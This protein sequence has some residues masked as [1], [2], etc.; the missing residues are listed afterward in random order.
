MLL[1]FSLC[2]VHLSAAGR[3][4]MP[5][6]PDLTKFSIHELKEIVIDAEKTIQKKLSE[7][8]RK[9]KQAAEDAAK[10]HGFSLHEIFGQGGAKATKAKGSKSQGAPKY[11]NPENPAQT[12]SGRGRQPAWFKSALERGKSPEEM[13]V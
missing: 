8:L 5:A 1:K 12:W 6:K 11:K 7:E 9:A 2:P 3:E 10:K 13:S 4:Y